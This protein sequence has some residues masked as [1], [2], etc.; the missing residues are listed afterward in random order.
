[1]FSFIKPIK[2]CDSDPS[3]GSG[4]SSCLSMLLLII[5]Y[6]QPVDRLISLIILSCS[7]WLLICHRL[8]LFKVSSDRL[9]KFK[10]VLE[11]LRHLLF[12]AC[13]ISSLLSQ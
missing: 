4:F 8:V 2:T 12:E 6:M 11:A 1:M 7:V 5:Y 10:G 3:A 13:E 9:Q